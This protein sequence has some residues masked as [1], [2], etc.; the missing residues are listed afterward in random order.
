MK[1]LP[2][3][4]FDVMKEVWKYDPPVT[5]G[6]LLKGLPK[7][8]GKHWKLQTLHTLLGR[9]VDRGFLRFEKKGKEK[10]FFPLVMR[11]MYLK[12]ETE[13]FVQRC[14]DGSLLNL[15]HAAYQGER[16]SNTDIDDLMRW[17]ADQRRDTT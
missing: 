10:L 3:A 6:M 12:Y 5:T 7:E 13:S 14:H 1:R 9:L 16:L 2:D 4:E 8:N 11:D 15:V 17:A